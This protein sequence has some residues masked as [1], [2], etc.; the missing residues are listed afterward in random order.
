MLFF[1]QC[2]KSRL[3]VGELYMVLYVMVQTASVQYGCLFVS[4]GGK[5]REGIYNC[6]NCG[7]YESLRFFPSQLLEGPGYEKQTISFLQVVKV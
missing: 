4:E 5:L 1:L 6:V 2:V 7:D 3:R